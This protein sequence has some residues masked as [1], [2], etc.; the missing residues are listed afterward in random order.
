LLYFGKVFNCF[1]DRFQEG[2]IFVLVFVKFLEVIGGLANFEIDDC[3]V[4]QSVALLSAETLELF[5]LVL[6]LPVEKPLLLCFVV[7]T[8]K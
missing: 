8:V 7:W 5:Q 4:I 1:S 3:Q 2:I 6:D